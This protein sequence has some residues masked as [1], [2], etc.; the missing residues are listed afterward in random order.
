MGRRGEVSVGAR[1]GFIRVLLLLSW[2]LSPVAI[3]AAKDM[4]VVSNK[5]NTVTGVTMT[6]LVKICKG[7]T[8]HWPD[9]KPITFFTRDP[10][11][12]DMKLVLE[13]IYGV[14]KGEVSGMISA[15]NHA[16][17]GHPAIVLVESDEILLRK[18]ESVPGA[19]GLV[20]VYSIN[21]R[22]AVMRVG[23]KLPFEA[24]YPLHGN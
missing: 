3:A 16:R 8:N 6:E 4:A 5:A 19:V 24:G 7:L 15:A 13:K 9:G 17:I 11:A 1:R 18:V 21:S 2:L 23:G 12:P 14:P 10:A 20:D 22:V